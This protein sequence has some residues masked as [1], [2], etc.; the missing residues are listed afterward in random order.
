MRSAAMRRRDKGQLG[1]PFLWAWGMMRSVGLCKGEDDEKTT[2]L[3]ITDGF[4]FGLG[5]TCPETAK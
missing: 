2:T 1:L 4:R 3:R 5:T